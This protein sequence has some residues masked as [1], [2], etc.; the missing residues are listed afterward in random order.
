[1]LFHTKKDVLLGLIGGHFLDKAVF[2]IKSGK[3]FRGSGDNWDIRIL[4]GQMRKTTQNEDLHLF[5]SNFIGN[6]VSFINLP[7]EQPKCD[8]CEL[9]NN[10]FSLS[11]PEWREYIRTSKII[12]GRILTRFFCKFSF[13]KK[14]IPD[15]IE[16]TYSEEMSQKSKVISMPI[17]NANENSYND[18]VHI[19][20][21][22]ESWIIEI[23]HRA[24][25]L[26]NIPQ[27]DDPEVP[28]LLVPPGQ[29]LAHSNFTE[30]DIM[31]EMKIVFSGDK[32]TRVR[33]AGAKH[34]LADAHTPIDR[35]EHCSPFKASMWHTKASLLQYSYHMLYNAES[36]A[37]VGTLKYF[38]EKLNRKN[39][40]PTKVVDS[41]EG[42]EESYLLA[43]EQR[44][45]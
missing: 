13:L 28:V 31:K 27:K 8:I 7:N 21:T 42:S 11:I 41:F 45:L 24:G 39:V 40:T 20:R 6:R 37:Q 25:L 44:I 10:N 26:P 33:F 30:N 23:Y 18:C 2:D 34:L 32:L 36:T 17:I 22:Y 19:L 43:W 14:C 38:R 5:S 35:F 1:M 12:I 16:H 4:K 3:T 29:P 15:H 9:S